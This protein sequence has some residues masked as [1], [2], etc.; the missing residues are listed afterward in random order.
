MKKM[1]QRF[2]LIAVVFFSYNAA[3]AQCTP[4]PNCTDPEGDGQYCPTQFPSAIEAEYYEETLTII[5]PVSQAGTDLHHIEL[6]SIG[7]IPP[8]MNYQCQDND[9]S[10]WPAVSK[11]VSVY[12]TPDVG[13]WGT[14]NLHLSIEVFIDFLGNPL[15]IG[16]FQDSSSFVT[17]E[18]Q[19]HGIFEID[20]TTSGIVCNNN[21]T[22]ITYTGNATDAATYNWTFGENVSVVSGDGQ[23]PYEIEYLNN[24]TGTDSISLEVQEG[25]FTSPVNT[26]VFQV[27]VCAAVNE[28]S[29]LFI[30]VYP[31]P[32]NDFL[33]IKAN[34]ILNGE[35]KLYDLG[36]KM[37][38]QIPLQNA[39]NP[40][41]MQNLNKGVYFLHINNSQST[42]SYKIIKN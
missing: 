11:C 16:V 34:G 27:D 21:L 22:S 8:G 29:E 7:N 15:S 4:D 26:E 9:C 1:I 14:Y 23:G 33:L 5:A 18:P 25:E 35:A 12:G 37:I 36:G 30:D 32:V 40:M 28:A 10:F 38:S 31:N 20:Y 39:T 6:I 2:L 3:T 24:Y 17:I 41:D 19:L 42:T 13:S